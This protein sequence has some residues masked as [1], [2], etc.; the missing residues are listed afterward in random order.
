[1]QHEEAI[2]V[3]VRMTR[4]S[5]RQEHVSLE[6]SSSF[7]FHCLSLWPFLLVWLSSCS[8]LVISFPRFRLFLSLSSNSCSSTLPSSSLDRRC[9]S[10]TMKSVRDCCSLSRAAAVFRLVAL[11]TCRA[12]TGLNR[13]VSTSGALTA[14]CHAATRG[15]S[16]DE[17]M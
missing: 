9:A 14:S 13:F 3:A 15:M 7:S 8:L 17:V 11:P 6:V 10:L 2:P 4:F 1:M 5:S 16:P 12:A